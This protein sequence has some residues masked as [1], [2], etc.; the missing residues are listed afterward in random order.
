VLAD[1]SA[2]GDV[3][4]AWLVLGGTALYLGAHALF[5]AVIWRLASWPRLVG[6]VSCLALLALAPHATRLVLA[7][8]ALAVIVA[9]AV[10]DRLTHPQVS[11]A[12]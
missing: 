6:T 12:G 11:Q 1:P 7:C 4:V 8:C 5:K 10:A 9:V 3:A 2:R